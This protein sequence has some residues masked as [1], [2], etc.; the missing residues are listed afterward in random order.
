LLAGS[1]D[2]GEAVKLYSVAEAQEL[3]PE[4]VLVLERLREAFLAMRVLTAAVAAQSRG[5]SGD[6]ALVANP[7]EPEESQEDRAEAL[8]R[9]VREAAGQLQAW[10]IELKDPERGLIDFY[11]ERPDAEVVFLCYLLGEPEIGYWHTLSGGFAGRRG[12]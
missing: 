2:E 1:I 6:G 8:N 3:L 9:D 4:V 5:A 11:H 7:W 10:G 12:L